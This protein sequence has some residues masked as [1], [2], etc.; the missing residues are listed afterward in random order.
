LLFPSNVFC[1][2]FR[3]E[4]KGCQIFLGTTY[5]NGKNIRNDYQN[6][7]K[8]PYY[9]KFGHKIDKMDLKIPASCIATPSKI[10]QIGIFGSKIYHLATLCGNEVSDFF[11]HFLERDLRRRLVYPLLGSSA[12]YLKVLLFTLMSHSGAQC[13]YLQFKRSRRGQGT[14]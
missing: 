4:I 9:I 13:K 7:P 8:W 12:G 6:G 14:P 11:Q 2:R 1:A 10:F 5:Q 3:L